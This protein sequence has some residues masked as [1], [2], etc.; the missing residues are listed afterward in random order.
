MPQIL[1]TVSVP[2]FWELSC[3]L[4][5]TLFLIT[6]ARISFYCLQT[7][8]PKWYK[9]RNNPRGISTK[10]T[11]QLGDRLEGESH[12]QHRLQAKILGTILCQ[13]HTDR[14]TKRIK[15]LKTVCTLFIILFNSAYKIHYEHFSVAVGRLAHNRIFRFHFQLLLIWWWSFDLFWSSFTSRATFAAASSP[16]LG[17]STCKCS[18]VT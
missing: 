3:F 5:K 17:N 13:V 16:S 11:V 18:I 2:P 7:K 4:P 15:P 8:K 10:E 1:R 9:G 14:Q 6:I 12:R